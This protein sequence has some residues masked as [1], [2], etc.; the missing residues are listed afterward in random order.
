MLKVIGAAAMVMA[1]HAAYAQIP[2]PDEV[3]FDL[4]VPNPAIVKCL[5]PGVPSAHVTVKR[6]ELNDTLILRAHGLRPN[7]KFDLFTVQ[8]SSLDA[9]GNPVTGFKGF[10][11]AWYQTDVN[12]DDDGNAK[13]LIRT[14]LLDQIFG[15]D[16]DPVATPMA[17][18]GTTGPTTVLKPTNTFHVGFWFNDPN[19]A[20][21]CGFDVSKPTPFNGE[22]KAGP[23]AMIS[24]P[25]PPANLGPLC[26]SPTGD[27][28]AA[29]SGAEPDNSTKLACNP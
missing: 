7:L 25:V 24:L 20:A 9:D 29:D 21:M 17:S 28:A 5:S 18:A 14:I 26:T 16:A 23:L 22:H 3:R 19:D 8:R 6:G 11:L 1:A 15:F 2:K 12:A 13:V 4:V 27:A 10:G